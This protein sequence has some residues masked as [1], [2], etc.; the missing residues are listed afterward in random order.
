M[1]GKTILIVED[2][3]LIAIHEQDS[4]EGYGYD[5][6][7]ASSGEEAIEIIEK[8][9]D[10]DLILMDIN[11]GSGMD[12][13]EAAA[14]ILKNHNLPIV[15]L[16]SHMEKEIVEKTEKITS[17]GYVVKSS[18]MTVLDASIK[19]AFK[20]FEANE[21]YRQELNERKRAE[22]AL[23][24]S[25]EHYRQ[26][27]ELLQETVVIHQHGN[28]VVIH[29]AG[30][31]LLGASRADEIL[32]K[33]ITEFI[34]VGRREVAL[35]RIQHVL[36]A[37]K[38]PLY[39]Q[40]L[41]R[42]DGVELNVEVRGTTF[43]YRGD[44]AVQLVVRDI[45]ARLRAEKALKESERKMQLVLDNTHDIVAFYNT[46]HELVW[47][48]KA[49]LQ[50]V[51]AITGRDMTLDALK[52]RKCHDIWDPGQP[53]DDCPI[54]R[55]IQSRKPVTGEV[56]HQ[57]QEGCSARPGWWW[58]QAVPV[59]DE[60]D[61]VIGVIEVSRNI[62]ARKH[63]EQALQESERQ[64]RLILDHTKEIIAF[65][66]ADPQVIWANKAYLQEVY[67]MT[68]VNMTLEALKERKCYDIWNPG[69]QCNACPITLALQNRASVLGAVTH[70][71]QE[72]WHAMPGWW[73]VQA[74][75]ILDETGAVVGAIEVSRNITEHKRT[76]EALRESEQ[77]FRAL[78]D[79]A[80]AGILVTQLDGHPVYANE[81]AA[82]ILGY[83]VEELL[84]INMRQLVP[85]TEFPQIAERVQKRFR[86]GVEPVP[87]LYETKLLHKNGKSIPV[88]VTGAKTVWQGQDSDIVLFY[89]IS[90]RKHAEASLR[91]SEQRFHTMFEKHQA[92]M[93]LIDPDSGAI[94]DANEAAQHYYGYP[95]DVFKTMTIQDINTLPPEEVAKLRQQAAREEYNYFVFSHRLASGEIRTVEVH[96]SPLT[97]NGQTIL[98]SII[99][100]ITARKQVEEALKKSEMELQKANA[101]KDKFFSIIAH[102]LKNAYVS[103]LS[104]VELLQGDDLTVE[105]TRTISQE[106][107][108]AAQN[109]HKLLENLLKWA[110][111]QSGQI[112][113]AP[114]AIN[115]ASLVKWNLH[116]LKE[117][118]AQKQISLVSSVEKTLSVYADYDML[119]DIL[120]NLI[121][122]GLKFTKPG[123]QVEISARETNDLVEICVSDTGIGISPEIVD[124][125]FDVEAKYHTP[126]T[127]NERG[128][129]LGLILCKEF[130]EKHA[131]QIWVESEVG[132]GSKFFF[133]LPKKHLNQYSIGDS[134]PTSPR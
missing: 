20:L 76:G 44:V 75:P 23:R 30:L 13:T 83:S 132:K 7:V 46:S 122:N 33:S 129:G 77:N 56:T 38:S 41:R 130:V 96:S 114:K 61:T 12:G 82:E 93:L 52:D 63:A 45:T 1:K 74:V 91:E 65:H 3:F 126:G 50:E 49:Y 11:L 59:I 116:L 29:P 26:I 36:T 47:A 113:F 128:T 31:K 111:N 110:R 119:E 104:G 102:D 5:V 15:F 16:S 121:F 69:E 105:R 123:G 66:N 85:P 62:T 42:L 14:Q 106:L 86:D 98:F 8:T 68:G 58:M 19:M 34:P 97:L 4:L 124:K 131:G 28:I 101:T 51:S 120:R 87:K 94:I 100:D 6:V 54:T 84:E 18:T 22:E 88:E 134:A 57:A 53:C 103:I 115:L 112:E 35:E 73:S 17:Y 67:A 39:E 109:Q 70:Q 79:N 78:A 27:V 117:N 72:N 40:T 81:R 127:A 107:Y 118:A 89:D 108:K 43:K 95:L 60:T 2:E 24:E 25:E 64:M 80:Q 133:T 99:H 90:K 125:L 55:A 48:N 92:V 71:N 9:P 37:G 21:K 32:G 10:I